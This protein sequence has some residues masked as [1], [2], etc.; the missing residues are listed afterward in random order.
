MERRGAAFI[1]A[2]LV[3][4]IALSATF[5][6]PAPTPAAA[7]E[8]SFAPPV[9][10]RVSPAK[11][12]VNLDPGSTYEGE[13]TVSNIGKEDFAF[14]VYVSPFSVVGEEYDHNY[15]VDQSYNQ[16]SRWVT[17][18][19]T[20]FD[21]PAGQSQTVN[22]RVNVPVDVPAGSQHA[23]LFAET[24]GSLSTDASGLKTIPRVGMRLIANITGETREEVEITEY[25]LPTLHISL[26]NSL[27]NA[28]SKI[29][30]TGNIDAEA[31]Y[32]FE[33][34]TFFGE[35]SVFNENQTRS[36]YPD[37]EFRHNAVWPNTPLLGLFY[38]TY[39]VSASDL[40]Q[41]ETRVVLVAPAWFVLVLLLLLT[42]LVIWLMLKFKKR[43]KLRSNV[44]L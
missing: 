7:A 12:S 1:L 13:F 29:K 35:D 26:D 10:P 27:I 39:S 44:Q 38:V 25:S 17:F 14:R 20:E 11:H 23:V 15:L 30:N 9:W 16:I 40:I 28:T 6:T 4:V 37:S 42:T 2:L 19:K 31:K 3:G 43:L 33:I 24:S 41:D 8:N 5:F 21:L 18:T 32:H 22:Y 36:I 34:K